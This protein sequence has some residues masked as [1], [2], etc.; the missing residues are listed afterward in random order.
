MNVLR[1]TRA[2]VR[3][4]P[5]LGTSRESSILMDSEINNGHAAMTAEVTVTLHVPAMGIVVT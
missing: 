5:C 1:M 4:F 2:A 3:Q